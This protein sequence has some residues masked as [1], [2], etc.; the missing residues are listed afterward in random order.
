[1]EYRKLPRGEEKLSTLGLGMGG[2]Q[3]ASREEIRA[4]IEKAVDNGINFFDLC[5]R[6][7]KRY[8]SRSAKR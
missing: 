6:R 7:T 4:V 3:S 1:M 5:C 2:I 8:T